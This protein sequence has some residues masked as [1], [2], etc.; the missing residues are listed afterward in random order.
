M[1]LLNQWHTSRWESQILQQFQHYMD[2]F[3][4]GLGMDSERLKASFYETYRR[5]QTSSLANIQ[6]LANLAGAARS[7]SEAQ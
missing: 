2:V 4:P 5:L 7:A 3:Y 6:A 1:F